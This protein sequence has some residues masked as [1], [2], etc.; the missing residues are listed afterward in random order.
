M[1][2]PASVIAGVLAALAVGTA[3]F[4]EHQ[5]DVTGLPTACQSI[6][7]SLNLPAGTVVVGIQNFAFAPASVAVAKGKPVTWVNCEPAGT[8]PHTATADDNSWTSPL[9]NPGQ[10]YTR[11]FAASGTTGYHCSPHP[12]MKGTVVVQ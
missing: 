1:R 9:L 7:A 5:V 6:V 10:T 12:F 2:V 11:T 3:C 4:S 8:V